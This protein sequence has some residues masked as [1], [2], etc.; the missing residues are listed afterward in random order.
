MTEATYG[1]LPG[2]IYKHLVPLLNGQHT[3]TEIVSALDGKVSPPE[4]FY[5]LSR[6]TTMGY[7]V[8]ADEGPA[9]E[10]LAFWHTLGFDRQTVQQRLSQMPVT[11][12]S[13]GG[14]SSQPLVSALASFGVQF[15]DQGSL[16]IVVT[17]DYLRPELETMNRSALAANRP[18]MLIK[19][20][21]NTAWIGPIF[22]PG[23]TGCWACLAQRLRGNRQVESYILGKTG[24]SNPL[25]TSRSGLVSAVQAG[26]TVAATEIVK[27]LLGA[28]QVVLRGQLLTFN[29]LSTETQKHTLIRRPQCAVCGDPGYLADK[30]EPKPIEL[31]PCKSKFTAESGHRT[32]FPE[33]TFARYRPHVSPI[34]GVV[35]SLVNITG[36]MN[37]IL[38]SYVAGHNFAMPRDDI[39]L[40]RHNLRGRSGGKGMTDIQAK[41]SAMS[42]A[43]ERYSGVYRG[44]DEITIRS[45]YK[46]LGAQALHLHDCLLFSQKQYTD[47]QAWNKQLTSNFHLVPNPFAEDVELEWSPLWSLTE[48]T[49]KYLPTV[50]CYYGHPDLR[51][52]FCGS[53]ANG[54]AA[55]NTLE[56]AIL[57]GFLELVERDAVALWWYNCIKR[58]KVDV[59][60]FALSYFDVLQTHYQKLN[61]SLWVLDLTSDLG[62]P[63]MAAISG[64]VDREIEDIIIG[65]GAH[66]D[67]KVAILRALTELNQFLPEVSQLEPDGSTKY[68]VN[69]RETLDW[70]KTAKMQRQSYLAPSEQLPAKTAGDYPLLY[71]NDLK[72]DVLTCVAIAQQAGL[73]TLVLD[74]TLPDVGMRVCRVVV[75]GLRHFWRRLGPGRLY[76]VPVKLGWLERPL[77]EDELNPYSLFF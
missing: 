36:E 13:I 50:Y 41:V 70:F 2:N 49:F 46:Q 27:W 75:P 40:L 28:N 22:E 32:V 42:E 9:H 31:A 34:T 61:R 10:E 66:L 53:D 1:V 54:C 12:K 74:Q 3:T 37:G 47:R 69:D 4:V 68:R 33:E 60:S 24:N 56:E 48:Q 7:L 26:A 43:I 58:P 35:S 23:T 14:V 63:V 30:R 29:F 16:D 59:N 21:G 25:K 15:S 76:D 45:T 62:I 11:L 5:A 38:Y 19:L 64:R 73:E 17:D 18:W 77:T 67:P 72:D 20:I 44:E 57:Q 55:G 52:F 8:E 71:K 39:A 6:L 65:F 51:W